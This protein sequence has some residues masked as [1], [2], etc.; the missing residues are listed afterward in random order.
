MTNRWNQLLCCTA[1]LLFLAACGGPPDGTVAGT[2]TAEREQR[3]DTLIVRTTSG[4][5]WGDT[6]SLVPEVAIGELE[7]SSVAA[8]GQISGLDVDADGRIIVLDRQSREVRIFSTD[9]EHALSF[10]RSGGGPGE[11]RAPDHLRILSDGRIIVRDQAAARFSV[12]TPDGKY[13]GGW[14]RA[15]GFSTTDP[16]FLD[17]AERVVNPTLSDRLVVYETNG[18]P[19][20]TIAVPSLGVAAPPRLEVASGG[21]VAWYTIPFM[22]AEQWTMTRDGRVVIGFPDRYSLERRDADGRVLRI[23]RATGRTPVADGEAAQARNRLVRNIRQMS[24]DWQWRG[25][26]IPTSKPAFKTIHAGIDGTIWVFR[27]GASV[28]TPNPE[29]K[30]SEPDAGDPTIWKAPII[31]DVFDEEGRY[32]GPV[33]IPESVNWFFPQPILSRERIWAAA[34]TDAGVPQVVRFRVTQLP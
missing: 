25:P 6:M 7:G 20:D 5:V 22:P 4:S 16:F 8:F 28:E 19:R 3:G 12:F 26:D 2:W 27:E 13:V 30:A 34:M 17:A 32:L 10:G 23:E 33:R 18:T 21:G 9:G 29:W 24:P 1:A 15:S 31:A 11:F 14:P